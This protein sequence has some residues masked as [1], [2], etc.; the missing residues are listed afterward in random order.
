MKET[1]RERI[2]AE[3]AAGKLGIARDRLH[4]LVVSY[5]DDASLRSRLGDVYWKLGYPVEAGRFW[6]LDAPLDRE[7]QAAVDLFVESCNS[8]PVKILRR[9]KLSSD[10][11]GLEAEARTRLEDLLSRAGATLPP[12]ETPAA[13]TRDASSLWIIGCLVVFLLVLSL[14]IIGLATVLDWV[15]IRA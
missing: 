11:P 4:G 14:A 3:I 1:T 6:F 12:V 15:K 9:L 7:K 5:P 2:E 13:E 8:H 10:L